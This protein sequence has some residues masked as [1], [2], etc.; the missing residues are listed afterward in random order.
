M[1][2]NIQ[3]DAGPVGTKVL[4]VSAPVVIPPSATQDGSESG[5]FSLQIEPSS[6]T[7]AS[8]EWIYEVPQTA[9]R[10]PTGEI[11]DDKTKANPKVLSAQWFAPTNSDDRLVD[12]ETCS[13]KIKCNIVVGRSDL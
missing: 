12:V 8:Y 1:V 3:H 13:Y 10:H 4:T 7:P 6:V 11:F 9:G 5:T 2:L